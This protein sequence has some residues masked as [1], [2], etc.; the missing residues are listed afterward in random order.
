ML[1]LRGSSAIE[2]LHMEWYETASALGG[3]AVLGEQVTSGPAFI[4][5]L[6]RGLP[7]S[8][9]KQ[10]KHYGALSDAD[11]SEVI[12]R[13]TLTS[14]K[15]SARLSAEQSDRLARVAGVV[16]LA[17]RVFGDPMVARDW[18]VAPNPSLGARV[19]LRLLR[20]G[21]GAQLVESVLGRIEHGVYE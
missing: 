15:K 20:T 1:Q 4:E 16:A 9:I 19:P 14:L 6:E 21:N 12:P 2:G 18:L 13:R 17:Q 11:L 8:A 3:T 5:R 10:L 7:R